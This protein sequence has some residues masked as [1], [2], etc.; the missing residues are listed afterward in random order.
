[1]VERGDSNLFYVVGI[2]IQGIN[3]VIQ[4][5]SNLSRRLNVQM[6]K[7]LHGISDDI[8]NIENIS[9]KGLNSEEV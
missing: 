6:L 3:N 2:H 8:L 7:V 9:G 4:K 5:G 1:M